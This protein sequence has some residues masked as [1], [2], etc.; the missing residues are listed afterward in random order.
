MRLMTAVAAAIRDTQDTVGRGCLYDIPWHCHQSPGTMR[1]VCVCVC[2][3][4]CLFVCL[5]VW[6]WGGGPAQ[7]LSIARAIH[8]VESEAA[9][10]RPSH[11][12]KRSSRHVLHA[13][14]A[15][16]PSACV[17]K[18]AIAPGA[19][20]SIWETEFI[21]H[22]LPPKFGQPFG[23]LHISAIAIPQYAL[24]ESVCVSSFRVT[25]LIAL[26]ACLLL[27]RCLLAC[28]LLAC[29]LAAC[30]HVACL[31]ACSLPCCALACLLACLSG[32]LF[33]VCLSEFL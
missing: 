32:C 25:W 12:S 8:H 31:L 15:S 9:H 28:L 13:A 24:P 2:V 30:L 29:L 5:F 7:A 1:G 26:L 4:V 6:W 27:A 33:V 17:H 23:S 21:K 19:A 11:V 18:F 20:I 22:R 10:C 16:H 14:V 3:C